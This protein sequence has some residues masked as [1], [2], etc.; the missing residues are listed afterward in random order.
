MSVD[1]NINLSCEYD[2]D[3][4]HILTADPVPQE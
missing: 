2:T 4:A 3:A 1:V